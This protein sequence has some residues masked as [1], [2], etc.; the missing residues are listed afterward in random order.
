MAR[1]SGNTIA[2]QQRSPDGWGGVS[3][4]R[5]YV[6]GGIGAKD[7]RT[8]VIADLDRTLDGDLDVFLREALVQGVHK[9]R[10]SQVIADSD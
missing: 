9:P 8:G 2:K 3:Q 6:V 10:S 7:M 4:V 5:C 1:W